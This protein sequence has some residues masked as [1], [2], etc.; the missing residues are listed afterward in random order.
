MTT[1]QIT[2]VIGAPI[3]STMTPIGSGVSID[4]ENPSICTLITRP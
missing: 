3:R 4:R 1:P 2:T